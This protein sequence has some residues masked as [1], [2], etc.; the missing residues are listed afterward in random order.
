MRGQVGSAA[1]NSAIRAGAT[2]VGA[3]ATSSPPVP[4][5]VINEVTTAA[6]AWGLVPVSQP[7][8]G[9]IASSATQHSGASANAVATVAEPR[10]CDDR[11]IARSIVSPQNGASPA[12][13][14]NSFANLFRTPA[15]R[16]PYLRL[17]RALRFRNHTQQR[18]N[19]SRQILWMPHSI[20]CAI[21]EATS[22]RST[23]SR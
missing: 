10:Q 21:P 5:F 2:A 14:I 12:A 20:S 16:Q 1:S 11:V 4:Q 18:R 3:D 15:P 22:R 23:P 19:R 7:P 9:N 17:Q 8:G 13:K 6:T